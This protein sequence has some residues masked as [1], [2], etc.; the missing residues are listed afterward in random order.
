ML[1]STW[2]RPSTRY[3]TGSSIVVSWRS[4]VFSSCR[5][6]NSVVV[7]PEPVGPTT[8][9]APKGREIAL[10]ERGMVPA[11]TT[12]AHRVTQV[13]PLREDAQRDLLAVRGWQR[14]H[15][16]V[17]RLVARLIAMRPSCGARRSAMSSPPMIFSRLATALAWLRGD[18]G[19]LAYDAV[20]PDPDEEAAL[21]RREVDVGRA[22]VEGHRDG[23]VHEDDRGAV[24]IQV[25][26]VR[27]RSWAS[28]ASRGDALASSRA[29][30]ITVRWR[31]RSRLA[32]RRRSGR[33]S[34]S[35]V[36]AR[37]RT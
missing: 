24:R 4:G 21:L 30:S 2:S 17:E 14:R 37:R 25:E 6:V 32:R 20:D 3:S 5:Q 19:E 12:R 29:P 10:L 35:R 15:P 9:T 27:R 8:T 36:E 33:A 16:D 23:P 28:A 1:T 18:R 13:R 22:G 34:R 7:L 11:A 26:Q 31:L